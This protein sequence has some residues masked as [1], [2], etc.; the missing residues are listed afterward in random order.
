MTLPESPVRSGGTLRPPP[1]RG[2]RRRVVLWVAGGAG[3]V[4][5]ALVA[6]F[7]TAGKPQDTSVLLGSPAPR[8]AGTTLTA[9]HRRLSLTDYAGKW[10][11]VDFAASYCVPCRQMLPRLEAF[12]RTAHRYDAAVLTVEETPSDGRSLARWLT[13]EGAGWP[14]LQDPK[15]TASYG[16]SGIP[17]VFLVDPDGIIVGYYPAGISPK[18]LDATISDATHAAGATGPGS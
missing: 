5:A 17:T 11:V 13:A 7:A 2:R 18:G 10:V 14:A 16:I 8:L 9:P 15:A 12:A 1:A 4:L 3:V 6:V